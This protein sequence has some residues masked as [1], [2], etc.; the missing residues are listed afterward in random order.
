MTRLYE[1]LLDDAA[2]FPPGNAPMSAA[3]AAHLEHKASSHGKFVGPLVCSAARLPELIT[4]LE[5]HT[6]AVELALVTSLADFDEAVALALE[7]ARLSLVSIE[8]TMEVGGAVSGI[9]VGVAVWCEYPWGSDFVLPAGTGLK[10][11]TGGAEASEFPT[12]QELAAAIMMCAAN[13]VPFKLTAGLHHA[14]RSTDPETGFE[15]HGFLNVILATHSALNDRPAD[16]VVA[17][18]ANRDSAHVTERIGRLTE[19]EVWAIRHSFH[20]FG[21]CSISDPLADL[22]TLGLLDGGAV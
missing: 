20:S 5:A 6:G 22:V 8:A 9:P 16:S 13:K 12:E 15:H 19:K 1:R 10:L 3:V 2:I 11:R 7:E 4:E 21:T 17:N 14:L 18:L